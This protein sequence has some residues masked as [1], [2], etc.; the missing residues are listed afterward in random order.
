MKYKNYMVYKCYTLEEYNEKFRNCRSK[1]LHYKKSFIDG[2]DKEYGTNTLKK[3]EYLLHNRNWTIIGDSYYEIPKA[4]RWA[5]FRNLK[6]STQAITWTALGIV[7]ATAIILPTVLVCTADIGYANVMSTNVD[8]MNDFKKIQIIEPLKTEDHPIYVASESDPEPYLLKGYKGV[9]DKNQ[10]YVKQDL[11]YSITSKMTEIRHGRNV[12]TGYGAF[13]N[14][15]ITNF[16]GDLK[17]KIENVRLEEHGEIE[18]ENYFVTLSFD[19]TYKSNLKCDFKP[20]NSSNSYHITTNLNGKV[21][22]RNLFV[23]VTGTSFTAENETTGYKDLTF[24]AYEGKDDVSEVK[25]YSTS[26]SK[27]NGQTVVKNTTTNEE[28]VYKR[29]DKETMEFS[30]ENP[31]DEEEITD[32]IIRDPVNTLIHSYDIKYSYSCQNLVAEVE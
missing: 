21:E 32:A 30:K 4:P 11:L 9:Y 2:F 10:D 24:Y 26:S 28:F 14:G 6:T 8:S 3:R 12:G 29:S 19:A 15:S 25:T 23:S 31:L 13:T 5:W 17:L 22:Y 16:G 20:I 27:A 7:A 18:N 1:L